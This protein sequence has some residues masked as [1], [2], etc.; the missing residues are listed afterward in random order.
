[1]K[2][3]TSP[4]NE[5]VKRT[6]SLHT[7]R[8]R[9]QAGAFLVEGIRACEPFFSHQFDLEVLWVAEKYV[10]WA[11]SLP[12]DQTRIR[13]TDEMVMRKM[14]TVTTPSGVIAVFK[15]P[16]ERS[17][18]LGPLTLAAVDLQDPGNMGT[19]IRTAA[20]FEVPVV[21][22][23]GV[24]IWS[25]KVVQASAGALAFKG[26]VRSSWGDLV[27]QARNEKIEISALVA[28]GGLPLSRFICGVRRVVVVGGE[29][30]GL[31]D[32]YLAD[33]Q[34]RISISM[35]GGTESLNA[36]VAGSIALYALTSEK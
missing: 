26:V 30:H 5:Q 12:I 17:L 36:A 29:A 25:P 13:L 22:I 9:R 19:I 7:S 15:Q 23:G 24:D 2:T 11:T 16:T 20:A 8:G 32:T 33:C 3:I 4:H 31:S 18:T 6:V 34:G 21:A 1:M 35:P 27:S 14:S 28:S 10:V